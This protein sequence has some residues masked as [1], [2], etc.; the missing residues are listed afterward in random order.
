LSLCQDCRSVVA[1]TAKF[2]SHDPAAE[3]DRHDDD[4]DATIEAVK[5]RTVQAPLSPGTRVSRY[6]IS[7]VIGVGAAG[8]VYR[9]YD[10]ELKRNIALKLLRTDHA[11]ELGS[12]KAR[13]LREAQAMAQLSHPNVVSVFDVGTYGDEIVIVLELVEGQTLARWLGESPRSWQEIRTAFIDA[14]KG[15]AAAHAVQLVHRDFK[16]ANVLVGVDG[17]VRV[18]DFGLARTM[19]LDDDAK[20]ELASDSEGPPSQPISTRRPLFSMTATEDGGLVGTPVYMAPEQFRRRRADARTDQ[21]SFCVALYMALYHRHPY[22]V[23]SSKLYSLEQLADSVNHGL[24]Q[25]PD[26]SIAPATLFEILRR[27]L[28]VDPKERF[29]SMQELLDN[30]ISDPAALPAAAVQSERRPMLVIAAAALGLVLVALLATT[31]RRTPSSE[32]AAKATSGMTLAAVP[33]N[34]AEVS[35][36]TGASEASASPTLSPSFAPAAVAPARRARP[37]HTPELPAEHPKARRPPPPPPSRPPPAQPPPPPPG[38]E[39]YVD[40]LKDPF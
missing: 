9:A 25:I 24:L 21:F 15:L 4:D 13:L 1:E 22:L 3:T 32:S 38:R 8:V 31:A 28:Q 7:D 18:T 10:P 16:P 29:G 6:V 30:L 40:G 27:G 12:L 20:S 17:R 39:R 37:A 36:P 19:E 14:G 35:D 33:S 11:R 23:A 5:R 26:T 2:F 34:S